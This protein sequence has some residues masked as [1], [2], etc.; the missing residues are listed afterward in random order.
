MLSCTPSVILTH[1]TVQTLVAPGYGRLPGPDRGSV[2]EA[3]VVSLQGLVEA[4]EQEVAFQ[5]E[6]VSKGPEGLAG[7]G[8]RLGILV[9]QALSQGVL[10][11]LTAGL[12]GR[13]YFKITTILNWAKTHL[14]YVE[15]PNV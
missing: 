15:R 14:Q 6:M 13:K 8:S 1:Q 7:P 10:D 12:G 9:G 11:S 4:A 5:L 3:E 2:P